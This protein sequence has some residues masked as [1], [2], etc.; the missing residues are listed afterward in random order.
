L[1]YRRASP[2]RQNCKQVFRQ[3]WSFSYSPW[4]RVAILSFFTFSDCGSVLCY[5]W[6]ILKFLLWIRN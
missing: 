2:R 1:W 4:D 3:L 6:W 5:W